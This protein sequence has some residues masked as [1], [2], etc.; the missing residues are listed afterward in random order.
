MIPAKLCLATGEVLYGF[1]PEWQKD[2]T[3]GEVVF[4]TG[5]TGYEETLTDPSYSGQII[6]FTY[7]IIGNYGVHQRSRWES[8]QIHVSG[9]ICQSVYTKPE[10]YEKQQTFLEWLH[11][12][13]IPLIV[14]IDTRHLTKILRTAGVINGAIVCNQTNDDIKIPNAMA[15]N[16]V[17]QVSSKEIVKHGSGKYKIILVDC[18]SKEN[19]LRLLLS[20]DTEVTVVPYNYDYTNL[21]Y[22]G[23]F[24]SNGPGDPKQCTTTI[25]ILAQVLKQNKPV[26][27]ICLGAQLM[28]L[29]VGADTYKLKFGHRGQNQPCIDLVTQKC[30]LTSQ[31]HGYA[32]DATT[33]PDDWC[34][35]FK[36]LN[37]NTVAGI[38][39]KYKPFAAVQFHPESAPGPED[40]AY[41]FADFINLVKQ[42]V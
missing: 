24:L 22:D 7:P 6:N 14:G 19:I 31:N 17:A 3:F 35:S 34:V 32:V 28:A 30:Y 29:A 36:N 26:Y 20:F 10:H 16:W 5:M 1:S 40:T 21:K 9:V 2:I 18:G 4:N 39:N 11:T 8:N 12:F 15:Q 13:K 37:D 42:G 38:K 41:F 23:V 33:L 27:G 25:A